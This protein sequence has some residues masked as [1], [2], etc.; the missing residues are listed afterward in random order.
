VKR[1][2]SLKREA[3]AELSPADLLAVAGG[4]AALPTS[5]VNYCVDQQNS[6]QV[7]FTAAAGYSRC[8]C[9]TEA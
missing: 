4:V 8:L 3:L 9:P 1:T 6:Q 2:L 7:C 5:P